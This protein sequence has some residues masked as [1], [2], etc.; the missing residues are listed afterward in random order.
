MND[1]ELARKLARETG[2]LLLGLRTHA[3]SI[4]NSTDSARSALAEEILGSEGDR[5]AHD[6]LLELQKQLQATVRAL[7]EN[8]PQRRAKLH[9]KDIKQ[10]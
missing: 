6:Y 2:S 8:A 7:K 3:A 10:E 4:S 5:V 1:H 9:S